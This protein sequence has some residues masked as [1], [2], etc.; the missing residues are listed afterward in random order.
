MFSRFIMIIYNKDN[1]DKVV[2][3]ANM[4]TSHQ[5]IVYFYEYSLGKGGKILTLFNYDIIFIN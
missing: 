3:L 1:S 4:K 2:F 5:Q